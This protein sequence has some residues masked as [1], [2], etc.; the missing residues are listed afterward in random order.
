MT[1]TALITGASSG[2]GAEFA[3]QLSQ[4]GWRLIV[5]ARRT[6][7]LDELKREIVRA[8]PRASVHI[9]T[10]DL[11]SEAGI[12][13]LIDLIERE[14]IDLLVNNAGFG[15]DGP[16]ISSDEAREAHE[17]AVNV[18]AVQQLTRAALPGMIARGRG[19]ILTVSSIAAFQ[20]VPNL[21]TYSGTK[22][23]ALSFSL[24][25]REELRG[26]GVGVT[27]LCPGPTMTGFFE[28]SGGAPVEL[29]LVTLGADEVVRQ[30]IRGAKRGRAVVIP[31][32]GNRAAVWLAN[33]VSPTVSAGLAG[34][35]L[36]L[37]RG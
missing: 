26:T 27:V 2:F 33:R 22:A 10:A 21:A 4:E 5:T 23:F 3:R 28:V 20:P 32:A 30:A 19:R 31:G 9:V 6:E 11:Q 14:E 16:F 34:L 7:K 25:L 37:T 13:T 29:P 35:A 15:T 17:I 8:L 18:T 36:R 24:A 12:R 1:R